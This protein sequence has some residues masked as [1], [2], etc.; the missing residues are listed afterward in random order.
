MGI[1]NRFGIPE[2]NKELINLS[3]LIDEYK[4]EVKSELEKYAFIGNELDF[5]IEEIK[6][7]E[8]LFKISFD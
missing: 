3:N 2:W 8:S 5:G 1:L 6:I 4:K 7:E